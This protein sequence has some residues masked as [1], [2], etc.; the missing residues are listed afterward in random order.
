MRSPFEIHT[1]ASNLTRVYI[2]RKITVWYSYETIIAFA[3]SGS[4]TFK[5]ENV[6]T[7][8]TAKHLNMIPAHTLTNKEFNARL[9]ILAYSMDDE[10]TRMIGRPSWENADYA[11][12]QGTQIAKDNGWEH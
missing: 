2:G 8:T 4:G 11:V 5:S 12:E 1:E 3:V 10:A 6:W 9:A 7:K